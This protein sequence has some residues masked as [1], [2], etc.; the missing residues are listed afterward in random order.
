MLSIADCQGMCGLTEDELQVLAEHEHLQLIVATELAAELL[1]T[2]RG[3]WRIRDCLLG[4]LE[5]SVARND[6]DRARRLER[7]ISGF[8][9]AHPIPPVL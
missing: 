4:E 7:I 6:L 1:K 9:S 2:P 8:I 3:T 5:K